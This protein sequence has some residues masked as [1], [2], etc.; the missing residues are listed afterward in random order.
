MVR[1]AMILIVPVANASPARGPTQRVTVT[2]TKAGGLVRIE[3]NL[4]GADIQLNRLE[5]AT[6][7]GFCSR[8]ARRVAKRPEGQP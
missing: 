3:D 8:I 4:S 2:E 1:H 5:L 7:A 6:L